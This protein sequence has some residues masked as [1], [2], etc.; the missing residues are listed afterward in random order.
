MTHFTRTSD[1]PYDR[2]RYKVWC[3]DGSVKILD[4][5]E[6]VMRAWWNFPQHL[7]HVEVLDTKTKG[8]GFK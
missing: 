8:G 6:D 3:V 4:D 2:H 7:S 5:Y 1:A